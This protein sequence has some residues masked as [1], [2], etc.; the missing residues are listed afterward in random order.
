MKRN[1]TT[2]KTTSLQTWQLIRT[3]R[4]TLGVTAPNKD[5]TFYVWH[6]F[7]KKNLVY[8]KKE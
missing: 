6:L 5:W 2:E 3:S 1:Q 8:G 7:L 4:Q